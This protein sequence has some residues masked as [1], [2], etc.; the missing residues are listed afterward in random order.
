[1]GSQKFGQNWDEHGNAGLMKT[2]FKGIGGVR[3]QIFNILFYKTFVYHKFKKFY[4]K[5]KYALFVILWQRE[6]G[7]YN[8][9]IG[10]SLYKWKLAIFQCEFT[11]W[12]RRAGSR[13]LEMPKMGIHTLWGGVSKRYLWIFDIFIFWALRGVQILNLAIFGQKSPK[14]GL[15]T[16]RKAQ[17]MKISKIH[18]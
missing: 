17:K 12:S 5:L 18:K 11:Q 4:G 16:P 3:G 9:Y 2:Q 14:I 13:A 7:E 6:V 1:M 8:K 10:K 15:W